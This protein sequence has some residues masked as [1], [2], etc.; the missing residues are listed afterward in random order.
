[1]KAK[2]YETKWE[3]DK[4]IYSPGSFPEEFDF[5]TDESTKSIDMAQVYSQD[6]TSP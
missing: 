5:S 3:W 2:V 6:M 1:M 4:W